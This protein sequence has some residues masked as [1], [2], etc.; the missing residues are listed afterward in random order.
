MRI[1]R[2]VVEPDYAEEFEQAKADAVDVDVLEAEARRRA[3]EGILEPVGLVIRGR[4]AA[5]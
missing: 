4:P 5:P 3:V 1:I 2:W